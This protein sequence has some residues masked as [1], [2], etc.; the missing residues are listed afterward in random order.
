[1]ADLVFLDEQISF[2]LTQSDG[3]NLLKGTDPKGEKAKKLDEGPPPQLTK[4]LLL[5]VQKS[6]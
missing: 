5:M 4:E 1:M 6:C 3:R 2:L